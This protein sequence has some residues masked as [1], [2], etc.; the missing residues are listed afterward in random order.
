MKLQKRF[1]RKYNKKDYYKYVVNIPPMMV[2]EAGLGG[3]DELELTHNKGAI[4]I[5]RKKSL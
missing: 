1:L 3:G 2:K 5:K 4:I